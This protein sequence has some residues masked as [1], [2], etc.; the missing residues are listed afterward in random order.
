MSGTNG[1][2]QKFRLLEIAPDGEQCAIIQPWAI[3][4]AL[5]RVNAHVTTSAIMTPTSARE[6]MKPVNLAQCLI[7][8]VSLSD[9]VMHFQKLLHSSDC[10]F[11]IYLFLISV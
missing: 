1:S 10:Y 9:Y 8:H 7:R 3:T 6:K 11:Y 5:T 2:S 4:I